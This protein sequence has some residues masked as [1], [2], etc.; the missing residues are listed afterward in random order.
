MHIC[1]EEANGNIVISYLNSLIKCNIS[2]NE[3]FTCNVY[4]T[5]GKSCAIFNASSFIYFFCKSA[6]HEYILPPVLIDVC[7]N[8]TMNFQV[9]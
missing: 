7:R 1:T 9:K 6:A 5:Y 8:I 4:F 3:S 2:M